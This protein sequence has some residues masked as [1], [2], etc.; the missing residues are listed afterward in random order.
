MGL[1]TFFRSATF[2][3]ALFLSAALHAQELVKDENGLVTG[4]NALEV[5]GAT[6]NVR[7]E[8]GSDGSY[9]SVYGSN[10]P[11]F[12]NNLSGARAAIEAIVGVLN[13]TN[14]PSSLAGF[15]NPWTEI[16]VPY[17]LK[18]L[19]ESCYA[20]DNS[21]DV[22]AVTYRQ[23]FADPAGEWFDAAPTC[24]RRAAPSAQ[25]QHVIFELAPASS[26][27][28][29]VPTMPMYLLAVLAGLLALVGTIRARVRS[30][31]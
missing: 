26:V 31:F 9:D 25:N 24:Y 17:E 19:S 13:S 16:R 14:P 23:N 29:P 10:T 20:P 28:T 27:A 8:A 1:S 22:V 15:Q 5:D 6:Y 7:F 30:R 2:F 11:A 3:G 21:L 4:I 12:L 18:E